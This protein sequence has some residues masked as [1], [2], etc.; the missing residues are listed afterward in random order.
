MLTVSIAVVVLSGVMYHICQKA[1]SHDAHPL[2]S[3][4]ITYSIA[5]VLSCAAFSIF[6]LRQGITESFRQPGWATYALGFA[7][8]G[9]EAGYLL[10]YRYGADLGSTAIYTNAAIA[11]LLIP[12]AMIMF[13]ENLSISRITGIIL[14]IMGFILINRK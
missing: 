10:A 7:I 12:A 8:F 5:I 6:P 2:V 11:V 3:L 13:G 9:L 1:I 14:C 4:I